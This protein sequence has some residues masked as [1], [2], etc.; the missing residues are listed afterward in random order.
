MMIVIELNT[1]TK[2]AF[3]ITNCSGPS[4]LLNPPIDYIHYGCIIIIYDPPLHV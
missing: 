3:V 1:Y 2:T 4:I